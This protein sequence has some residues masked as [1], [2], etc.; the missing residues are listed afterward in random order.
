MGTDTVDGDNTRIGALAM[1][2]ETELRTL[3]R[4]LLPVHL[5]RTIFL[6][7]RPRQSLCEA[8][9]LLDNDT[10]NALQSSSTYHDR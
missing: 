10:K 4:W 8:N 2:S 6:S 1:I 7:P 9:S 3:T 5:A